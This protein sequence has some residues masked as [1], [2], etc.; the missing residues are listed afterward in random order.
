MKNRRESKARRKHGGA[1]DD[2]RFDEGAAF[3]ERPDFGDR[4]GFDRSPIGVDEDPYAQGSAVGV[5]ASFGN[6]SDMFGQTG[7]DGYEDEDT[8]DYRL[9]SDAEQYGQLPRPEVFAA[10]PTEVQ[11]KILEWTDRDVRARR[12]DESQRQDMILRARFERERWR[13]VIPVLIIVLGM[14]CAAIVGVMT[15]RALITVAFLV[16]PVV[17]IIACIVR[18]GKSRRK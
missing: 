17:V 8:Y 10:Y 5:S 12:D 16:I 11:R 4:S 7:D 6:F 15:K 13:I 1:S 9:F 14:L 3:D 18:A 2:S